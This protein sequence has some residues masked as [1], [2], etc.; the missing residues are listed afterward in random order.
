[1]ARGRRKGRHGALPVQAVDVCTRS[2]TIVRGGIQYN[3]IV[4]REYKDNASGKQLPVRECWT[5][6]GRA[7]VAKISLLK[8]LTFSEHPKKCDRRSILFLIYV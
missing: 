7:G 8:L 2:R 6:S 5:G 3:T 1:M 4:R